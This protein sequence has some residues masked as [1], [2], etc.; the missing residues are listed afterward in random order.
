MKETDSIKNWLN[1]LKSVDYIEPIITNFNYEL[2]DL[3][4]KQFLN[5]LNKNRS[6]D[7]KVRYTP[8][9]E[10]FIDIDNYYG[11]G[12]VKMKSIEKLETINYFIQYCQATCNLM[13][14]LKNL[15]KFNKVQDVTLLIAF[16]TE[17]TLENLKFF[18]K[19]YQDGFKNVVFCAKNIFKIA[20]QNEKHLKQFDS[21]TLIENKPG[22]EYNCVSNLI[23]INLK[24]SGILQISDSY[25]FLKYWN[26]NLTNNVCSKKERNK[27]DLNETSLM[28]ILDLN[29]SKNFE[30]DIYYIP[31]SLFNNFN[32][33]SELFLK[34][35]VSNKLAVASIL[36][37]NDCI[38]DFKNTNI[39]A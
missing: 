3:D 30:A 23:D 2:T 34:N 22:F 16:K 18:K 35:M 25:I 11:Q 37:D 33:L 38:Q 8:R 13:Y 21:F 12:E 32:I 29:E 20:K 14:D 10:T 4:I 24:T 31:K 17:A 39:G 26:L 5:E 6:N 27:A 19:F 7:F 28:K 9:F 36:R 15:N 1:D